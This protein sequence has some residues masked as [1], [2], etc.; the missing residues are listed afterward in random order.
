MKNSPKYDISYRLMKERIFIISPLPEE[1]EEENFP[2]DKQGNT[3]AMA[4]YDQRGNTI[5][6]DYQEQPEPQTTI[7]KHITIIYEASKPKVIFQQNLATEAIPTTPAPEEIPITTPYPQP[8]AYTSRTPEPYEKLL[9][10]FTERPDPLLN[11][12]TERPDPLL[13]FFTERPDPLLNFFTERPDPFRNFFSAQEPT[14][15]NQLR[16][17]RSELGTLT[18]ALQAGE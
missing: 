15:E 10:F 9:N 14:E 5:D 1:E 12:F 8:E 3:T 11:F 16:S 17:I 6:T 7:E 2:Y 4:Y 18:P 13:N